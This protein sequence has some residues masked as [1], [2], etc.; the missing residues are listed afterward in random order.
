MELI[1]NVAIKR[2]LTSPVEALKDIRIR[3]LTAKM[4]EEVFRESMS[5]IDSAITQAYYFV[6]LIGSPDLDDD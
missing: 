6:G 2:D 3:D 5:H 4:P 1:I